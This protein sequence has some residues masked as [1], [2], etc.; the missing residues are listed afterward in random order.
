M[1]CSSQGLVTNEWIDKTDAFL[2]QA[3]GEATK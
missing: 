3:F 1:G 2:E